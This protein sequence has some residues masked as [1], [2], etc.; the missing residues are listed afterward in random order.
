MK[1]PGQFSITDVIVQN[2]WTILSL[3]LVGLALR[4]IW[5][6][7]AQTVPVSD[8]LEY[9]ALGQNIREHLAFGLPEPNYWRLPVYPAFLA[10]LMLVS[11]N[12]IWLGFW[13][14]LLSSLCIVQ[15]Y[16][17][18]F[19]LSVGNRLIAGIAASVGLFNITLLFLPPVL[20]SEFLFSF[21]VLTALILFLYRVNRP[22]IRFPVIG[23][24]MGLSVLTRGE[25]LFYIPVF[26][27][28]IF[29]WREDSLRHALAWGLVFVI[30]CVA[31]I[32]P[33]YLR[34]RSVA[35]PGTGLS[36]LA[37]I[38]FY[39]GHNDSFYGWRQDQ[40]TV[41]EGL[42]MKAAGTLGYALGIEYIKKDPARALLNSVVNGTKNL[43]DWSAYPIHMSRPSTQPSSDDEEDQTDASTVI[44]A[45]L[46]RLY[47]LFL[48]GS[49][50]SIV[51]YRALPARSWVSLY[52]F[53]F[54]NWFGY[55]IL[56]IGHPRY[57]FFMEIIFCILSGVTLYG[58][59]KVIRFVNKVCLQ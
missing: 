35:G 40:G 57:R 26:L 29:M 16:L 17:I 44:L 33:W 28:L 24:L 23:V 27:I 45:W 34:N 7:Y 47:L 18:A 51:F 13:N 12:L 1:D 32:T 53:V 6:F 15:I 2:R 59:V 31:V 49:V 4:L 10:L 25:G 22:I 46:N 48:I 37:G 54:T 42:D 41:F 58:V 50:L 38:N 14:V 11:R 19:R 30:C 20:A 5:L 52:L 36:P 55:V 39:Y 3:F 8:F 9:F 56:F 43:F 21:F